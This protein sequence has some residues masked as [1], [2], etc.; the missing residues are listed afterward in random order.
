MLMQWGQFL[1]HD[2]TFTPMA[3]SNARFSDGRHCNETCENQSPCF[4]IDVP[5]GDPRIHRF[6]C[7]GF[8]RSSS[9]CGTGVTS[10][11]LHR[12]A[13][14][15]QLNQI[16]SYIDA[17]NVYGSSDE[18]ANNLRDLTN[19][20]GF[21]K[22]GI[23]PRNGRSFLPYNIHA[24]VDC[25]IDPNRAHIPCFIAGD[26]R[27][28]EQLGLLSLHTIYMRE[29][30]RMAEVLLRNNPHWDGDHVYHETRKIIGATM[31]HITYSH[32]LPK[33]LG[34]HGM[35]MLGT[36]Q[37]Y[38]PNKDPTILNVFATAAFRFGHSLIQPIIYRLDEQ[39]QQTEYGNLPLHKAFFAP[40]RLVEEGGVDPI[41]RGLFH[42]GMK[43]PEPDHLL[44]TE[45]TE[46]L[47]RLA[48]AVALDLA[49]LN[50]QR[51][52]DHGLPSYNSFR[53][54]CNLTEARSF[55]DFRREI[56]NVDILRKLK[57]LYGHPGR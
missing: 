1:D 55:T 14:R 22:V 52:R 16:T 25:Q 11:F 48:H 8:T 26:H 29:H 3:V 12:V 2:I 43:K 31:Q 50:I 38:N 30:N 53:Q 9:M 45:L 28:N 35:K 10:G 49:A 17:S 51:G 34:E 56:Q 37:G 57:E 24:P 42:I 32:W 18:E 23:T 7:L 33:I 20:R 36:Y 5:L 19:E 39:F 6:K 40:Y 4:P 47:F 54:Y 13:A 27:A 44:N 41:L 21:L 15:Q 46:R